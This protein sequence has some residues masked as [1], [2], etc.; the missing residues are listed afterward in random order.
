[1]ADPDGLRLDAVWIVA[2]LCFRFRRRPVHL[3]A[4]LIFDCR[5]LVENC[6]VF[7]LAA[8][9]LVSP[10]QTLQF[11]TQLRNLLIV[12]EFEDKPATL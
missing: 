8:R 10:A 12:F 9:R 5:S 4:L 6:R 11:H 7:G 1:M 3:Y 2:N